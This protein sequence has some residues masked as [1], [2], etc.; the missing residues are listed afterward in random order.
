MLAKIRKNFGFSCSGSRQDFR[1]FTIPDE[2]LDEFCYPETRT[3]AAVLMR[4]AT[5]LRQR[6]GGHQWTASR[7][8]GLPARVSPLGFDPDLDS[9]AK[10]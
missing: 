7:A 8:V 2:T 4:H 3:T 5:S 10:R 1:R 6:P 9:L